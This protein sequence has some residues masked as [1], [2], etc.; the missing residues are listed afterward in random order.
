VYIRWGN[1]TEMEDAV[2]QY[3]QGLLSIY[4]EVDKTKLFAIRIVL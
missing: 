1:L 3:N 4:S 2:K